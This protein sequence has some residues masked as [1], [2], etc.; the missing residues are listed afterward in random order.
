EASGGLFNTLCRSQSDQ[1]HLAANESGGAMTF[2][3]P[4]HYGRDEEEEF[5]D[6]GAYS[7]SLEEDFEE[8]EEEEESGVPTPAG[9][10]PEPMSIPAPPPPPKPRPAPSA[11]S[12]GGGGKPKA[13]KKA[14]KKPPKKA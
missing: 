6:S 4:T 5:G 7:E 10:E 9:S 8:E 1:P 11:P 13:K 3:D 14:A 2:N 12:G